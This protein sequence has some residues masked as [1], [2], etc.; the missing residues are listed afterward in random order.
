[1]MRGGES[2]SSGF[3]CRFIVVENVFF[4]FIIATP[5]TPVRESGV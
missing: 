5:L 4:A 1:M 2:V 3:I